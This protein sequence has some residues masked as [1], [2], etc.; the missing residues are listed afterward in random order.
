LFSVLSVTALSYACSD[1]ETPSPSAT[2]KDDAGQGG[3]DA[4]SNVDSS[5][6]STPQDVE[7]RFEARVGTEVFACGKTFDGVGTSNASANAGDFRFFV[8]D[9]RLLNGNDELPVTLDALEPWQSARLG[10][11]DFEDKTGECEFGTSGTNNV[12]RGKASSGTYD[13][14]TFTIGV[15]EDLNH[16]NKDTEAAPLPNSGLNWDWTTGY[17]HFAMQLNSTTA[18]DGG[19]AP[20]FFSHVGSTQCAGDPAD[21]GTPSCARKNRAV[22][23]LMGFDPAKNKILVD[24]K[25]LLEGSNIDLNTPDTIPGCMSSPTDPECPAVF[26]RLGLDIATGAPGAT[27]QTVFSVEAR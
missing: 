26:T 3:A 7:I 11:L 16:K 18:V 9:I 6:P 27:S 8:H 13:G 2:P 1:D 25:K 10:L 17:I 12:L 24:A 20:S 22:V 19:R 15:P 14:I 4:A 5:P 21:G 23:R